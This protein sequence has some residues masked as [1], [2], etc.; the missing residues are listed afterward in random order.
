MI[1]RERKREYV[2]AGGGFCI[3]CGG[4]NI[5]AGKIEPEGRDAIQTVQCYDC[6]SKWNDVFKL[7]GVDDIVLPEDDPSIPEIFG[8]KESGNDQSEKA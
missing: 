7:I 4:G 1:S 3:N 5:S 8:N 6:G 2:K